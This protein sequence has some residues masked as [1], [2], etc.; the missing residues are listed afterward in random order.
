MAI[1]FAETI[2]KAKARHEAFIAAMS[3]QQALAYRYLYPEWKA[4]MFY[5]ADRRIRIGDV[6]YRVLVDHTAE[7]GR[8]PGKDTALYQRIE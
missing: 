3:D 2:A 1:T 7:I 6:L 8:E 5:S 4:S